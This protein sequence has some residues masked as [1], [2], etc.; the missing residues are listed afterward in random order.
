[1][2]EI[3]IAKKPRGRARWP[4]V[5]GETERDTRAPNPDGPPESGHRWA[6][7]RHLAA[8]TSRAARGELQIDVFKLAGTT[9][10][11]L[12]PQLGFNR[13][14]TAFLRAMGVR[15]GARSLVMGP[16]DITVSDISIG[17]DSFITGPMRIDLGVTVSI[18]NRVHMGQDILLLTVDHE[19][20]RLTTKSVRPSAGA[21]PGCGGR[22][23]S[24]TGCG[25]A[26]V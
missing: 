22:L 25:S 26:R 3:A 20:S 18:G 8:R 11:R 16:L 5:S 6:G 1:M 24:K 21:V 4:V 19:F 7:L 17:E 9:L 12:L 15:V 14:R 13:T 23:S 2:M 10:S